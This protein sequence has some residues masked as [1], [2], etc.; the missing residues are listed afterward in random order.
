MPVVIWEIGGFDD[1]S[2]VFAQSTSSSTDSCREIIEIHSNWIFDTVLSYF[3]CG[4]EAI[5][6]GRC[7]SM[8]SE[9]CR[10]LGNLTSIVSD[11]EYIST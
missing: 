5:V 7:A 8:E 9:N 10:L 3:H 2:G 11:V 6:G 1:C 4:M